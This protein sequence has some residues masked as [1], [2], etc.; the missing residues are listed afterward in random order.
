MNSIFGDEKCIHSFI[1]VQLKTK[2]DF[3]K[4]ITKE[5]HGVII[6]ND[7]VGLCICLTHNLLLVVRL[8]LLVLLNC[9]LARL[10]KFCQIAYTSPWQQNVRV[11]VRE[12]ETKSN[13]Q[14]V[15]FYSWFKIWKKWIRNLFTSTSSIFFMYKHT[16]QRTY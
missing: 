14:I 5:L 11:W 15:C 12:G 16:Q 13:R 4:Y 10:M 8:W 6:G 2:L 1:M 3:H 7:E 9:V